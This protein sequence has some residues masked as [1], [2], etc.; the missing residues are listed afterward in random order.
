MTLQEIEA[1]LA[2]LSGARGAWVNGKLVTPVSNAT[3]DGGE[4]VIVDVRGREVR[5]APDDIKTLRRAS[6]DD[7]SEAGRALWGNL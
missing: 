4:I 1:A 7:C 6:P 3:I 5:L 2:E